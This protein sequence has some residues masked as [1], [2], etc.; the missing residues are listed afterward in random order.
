VILKSEKSDVIT[1]A[2]KAKE[3]VAAFQQ[4]L[5]AGMEV[6]ITNDFSYYVKRRLG[7]LK[8]N[9]IIGFFLVVAT[10]FAFMHFIPALM[11][12]LG[13]PFAIFLTVT[14]MWMSGI[15]INLISMLGMII[16]LGMLVDDGIIIS[17]NVYRYVEEGM[18]PRE[19][20]IRG[21]QEVFVPV[22]G[23]IVTT[24]AAFAPLLFMNDIIGKFIKEVPIV[25]IIALGASLLEAFIIL[26]SHL[27]DL[28]HAHHH[29][30]PLPENGRRHQPKGWYRKLVDGYTKFLNWALDH[31][32]L[33][34]FG[35]LLPLLV[36]AILLWVFKV[37]FVFFSNEGIEQ[38]F[39]RAEAEKGIT[40]AKM[41]ELIA[42]VEQ[43]VANLPAEYLE[44]FRTYLGSIEEESGFDPNAKYGTHLG[45]ITVFL[46]PFQAR[47][48]SAKE[49]ADMLRE[50]I[51]EIKGF[52]KLYI[53]QRRAGPPVGKPVSVAIKGERFDVLTGMAQKFVDRL[54]AIDGVMDVDTSYEFGKKEL[55]VVVDEEKARRSYLTVDQ[56][57]RDVR[58]AFKGAVA[59]TVKPLKAEEEIDVVVRFREEDRGRLDAF[60]DI[61]I[62]NQFGKLVPLESVAKVT[63]EDS[64]YTVTHKNGKRVVYVT[65]DVDEDK[66]TALEV[67]QMIQREFSDLPKEDI[68][69]SVSYTGEFEK[70]AESKTNLLISFAIAMCFIFI[71]LAAEFKSLIQPFIVMMAIPFGLIGVIYAFFLHGQ[72]LGFFALMGIVGLTGIVVNDSIVL[73][74]FI[75]R[76]RQSGKSRRESIVE[77]GQI[78]LRPV[79]MT[80]ITTV[81][82]LVSV[83]YGIGGGDPFLKPLAL[84]IVWGL[85]FSTVLTLVNIPCIYALLDDFTEHVLHRHMVAGDKP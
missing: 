55:K 11:T 63:E 7:V 64:V 32:K 78:R 23:T 22:L 27:A 60:D 61:L 72:P 67:N 48:K 20:A 81:A 74:D 4:S 24:W 46:T 25:V 51:K 49:I 5:P 71:I 79:L 34:V 41:D 16:V 36:S 3:V 69:Y 52:D 57:A 80:S 58:T 44:S 30:S 13:I 42:P 73:V 31:R 65:A 40:L 6:T 12:A 26:P 53:V 56:I 38:F 8:N 1:V 83:A 33:F 68:G 39:V 15:T 10:L 82:G 18:P 17:E 28:L 35:I 59:T 37:K 14:V 77:A 29:S 66:I 54:S 85:A 47:D 43:A 45:Q 19:A 70:Q 21:T 84:A 2:D 62:E 75:N 76:A 50:K 9:G